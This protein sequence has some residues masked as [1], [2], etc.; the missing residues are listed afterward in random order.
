MQIETVSFFG[1]TSIQRMIIRHPSTSVAKVLNILL[2]AIL[3]QNNFSLA[4]AVMKIIET[5]N[6]PSKEIVFLLQLP[7][8]PALAKIQF[9]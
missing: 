4:E 9:S 2:F 1:T 7:R 6:I 3:L 5:S 8:V